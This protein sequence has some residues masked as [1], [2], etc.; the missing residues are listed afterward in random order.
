[1]FAPN[2]TP[3]SDNVIDEAALRRVL[4]YFIERGIDGFVPCGTTGESATMTHEEHR[5]VV[6]LTI[7][8]VDGRVPVIAGA[9]S[10]STAESVELVR[11][12]ESVGADGVLVICPYYNKPTQA[13]LL[14]HFTTVASSTSLPVVMYNIPSRTGVN[15]EAETTARLSQAPNIVGVKEA[16]GD[17]GQVGDI[18]RL[19]APDFVV[20][21][22]DGALTFS[23][24]CLGG[25]GGILADAHILPEVW[26]RM[27]HLIKEGNLPEAR[28]IHYRLLPMTDALFCETN[29]SPVKA[30]LEMMGICSSQTRL[31]LLPASDACRTRLREELGKLGVI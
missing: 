3:F 16:S 5:Q 28:E 20:L 17:L 27:V 12:A 15:L 23:I 10:N 19:A 24:C 18:I 8:H 26:Q 2:V 13:G 7:K 21:S 9:G 22:G 29:P 31:P 11:H 6:E 1:M 14:E 4:D 30:A 25:T